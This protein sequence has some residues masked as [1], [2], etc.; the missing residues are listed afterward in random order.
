ML[1]REVFHP[2]DLVMGVAKANQSSMTPAE[3]VKHLSSTL[4]EA[5]HVA[6]EHLKSNLFKQKRTYDLRINEKS[7][8]LG[9]IVYLR[10][11]ATK[12]NQ[13]SKLRPVWKGLSCCFL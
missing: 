10:D 5:H 4:Q 3:W 1:G 9:D 13:S 6:R 2:E 11:T 8:N 12:V 7:F